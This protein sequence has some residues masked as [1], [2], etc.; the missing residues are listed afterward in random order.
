MHSLG[1][2]AIC[3]TILPMDVAAI[4]SAIDAELSRLLQARNLLAEL[5]ASTVKRVGRPKGS[6][7]KSGTTLPAK[8]VAK[9]RT[10][11]PEGRS[12]VAAAQ[13]ARWA[14][15]KSAAKKPSPKKS[16]PSEP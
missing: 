2:F 16:K 12:R 4:L 7:I 3:S 6:G 15:L 10:M 9:K 5:P 11:S 13:K 14:A 8:K 1:G